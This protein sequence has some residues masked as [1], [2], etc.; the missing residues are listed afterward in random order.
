MFNVA[1]VLIYIGLFCGFL[2]ISDVVVDGLYKRSPRF[3]KYIDRFS[4]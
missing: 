4:K 1:F 3:K 2:V